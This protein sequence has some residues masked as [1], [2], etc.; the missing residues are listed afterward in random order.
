MDLVPAL[1]IWFVYIVGFLAFILFYVRFSRHTVTRVEIS[2]SLNLDCWLHHR[3]LML[4]THRQFGRILNQMLCT[5]G[6]GLHHSQM[7]RLSLLYHKY[8][9]GIPWWRQGGQILSQFPTHFLVCHMLQHLPLHI[10]MQQWQVHHHL[11]KQIR[12]LKCSTY[13]SN[14]ASASIKLVTWWFFSSWSSFTFQ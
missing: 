2:Q 9:H 7:F 14:R 4:V 5:Q 6:V 12:V 1:I 3:L 8:L 11:L 13:E 10:Q